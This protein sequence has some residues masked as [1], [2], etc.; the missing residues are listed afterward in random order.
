MFVCRF[1]KRKTKEW[2]IDE[3]KSSF[4]L[5]FPAFVTLV[6]LP[7]LPFLVIYISSTAAAACRLPTSPPHRTALCGRAFRLGYPHLSPCRSSPLHCIR[8]RQV[9]FPLILLDELNPRAAL[10]CRPLFRGFFHCPPGC[11]HL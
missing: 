11:C 7:F 10:P 3:E 4:S 1:L 2:R 5:S 9:I 6:I 8:V